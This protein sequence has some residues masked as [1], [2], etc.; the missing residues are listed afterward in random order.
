MKSNLTVRIREKDNF[1]ETYGFVAWDV[2]IL[3]SLF[4]FTISCAKI[5]LSRKTCVCVQVWWTSRGGGR[6]EPSEPWGSPFSGENS[7]SFQ[8]YEINVFKTN[9]STWPARNTWDFLTV[10][11]NIIIVG[12][13]MHHKGGSHNFIGHKRGLPI[14][15]IRNRPWP[16]T[17]SP[18]QSAN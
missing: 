14:F 8:K 4:S 9:D 7:C 18:A 12:W 10:P 6:G 13:F 17:R 5:W 3:I 1:E 11:I 2:T 16:R 15:M